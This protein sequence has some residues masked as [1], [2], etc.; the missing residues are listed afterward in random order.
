MRTR[1]PR[2]ALVASA[3]V[4]ALS[5]AAAAC[6]GG[7]GGPAAGGGNGG[8]GGGS[9]GTTGSGSGAG[10]NAPKATGGGSINPANLSETTT[11]FRI[12]NPAW[13]SA[14]NLNPYNP[15][16]LP[17]YYFSILDLAAYSNTPRPG[18]DPYLPEMAS[19]WTTGAHS[20]TFHLRQGAKWQ[21]GTAFTSKDVV[22]SFLLAGGDGNSVWAD[23]SKLS[24]PNTETVVVDLH[25]WVVLKNAMD[26]IVRIYMV[27]A[28]QYGKLIPSGFTQDLLSYWKTYDFLKPTKASIQ[29]AS[30]SPAG[31]K[32]LAVG[33][34]LA[35]FDPPKPIGS[36]PYILQSSS[37]SGILFKKW[38]GWWDQSAIRAPWI[39]VVPATVTSMFGGLQ[40]GTMDFEEFAQLTDPQ[41]STFQNSHAGQYIYIP[42]PVQQESLVFHL[43]DYPYGIKQVRQALAYIIDRKKVAQLDMG[44]TL[45]QDPPTIAPD[46]V[47]DSMSL[48]NH[49]ITQS[50]MAGMNHYNYSPAKATQLLESVGFKKKGGT[51]YTPKGQPWTVTI[52]E[53]AGV[54]QFEEDG[55]AIVGMLKNF[56][57]KAQTITANAATYQS[58]EYAG[59]Y[60][61]SENYM[62][63]GGTSNPIGDFAQTFDP[64]TL[65]A[66]NYPPYYSGQ[67][68]F[69]GSVAIG[70]G[71]ISKVPGLGTVN[72]GAELNRELNEAPPSEWAKYT[73]DW[74]RWVDENLPIL[75]LYNNA[76]HEA[77]S[78]SRYT[79]FPPASA[80][81]LWTG[82]GGA[83]QPVEWMQAGYLQLKHT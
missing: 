40:G 77:V 6:G 5:L 1:K 16:Q 27:P 78:D 57:I 22:D 71:P 83:A 56:G 73:Y 21:D 13:T 14:V 2:A 15:N 42:S 68:K 66:Y 63:W 72:V 58:Q 24:A 75:P 82:L 44:G 11:A 79:D 19:S 38:M 36:G 31:K 49:Y 74:A 33:T 43:A 7:G 53:E 65:P 30:S 23:I 10:A 61:I 55:I 8:S 29:A 47:N 37:V 76:F 70:I 35:K 41:V 67:G 50:Q 48:P 34:A 4:A 39:Q 69:N 20:I 3:V 9:A 62:D 54:A 32:V 52:T 45:L 80:K 17:F 26:A 28:E 18:K 12:A 81:W 64:I 59:D 46:G 60:A 51:W 25:S